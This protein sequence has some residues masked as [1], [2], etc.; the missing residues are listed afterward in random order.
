MLFRYL[1]TLINTGIYCVTRCGWNEDPKPLVRMPCPSP[2]ENQCLSHVQWLP[3]EHRYQS[4]GINEVLI[5]FDLHMF[6]VLLG[7]PVFVHQPSSSSFLLQ[8]LGLRKG[9][10]IELLH[11]GQNWQRL[12]E[13]PTSG[14]SDFDANERTTFL[15]TSFVMLC[16][17]CFLCRCDSWHPTSYTVDGLSHWARIKFQTQTPCRAARINITGLRVALPIHHLLTGRSKMIEGL[18]KGAQPPLM[19]S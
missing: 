18:G 9:K 8:G 2:P 7:S 4:T 11:L 19:N 10:R 16:G 12:D 6:A 13:S 15:Q 14:K 3:S 17:L 5:W 1:H